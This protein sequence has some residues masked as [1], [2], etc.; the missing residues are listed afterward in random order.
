LRDKI[1]RE[2]TANTLVHREYLNSFP[3]RLIIE[4]DKVTVE[5]WNKPYMSGFISPAKFYTHPKNPNILEVFKHIGRAEELG[6][7]VRNVF[8]YGKVYGNNEPIF[9]EGDILKHLFQSLL[10]R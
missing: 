8:K 9:D 6:S 5:N 3:S 7:S 10:G 4:K 2:V 1:F